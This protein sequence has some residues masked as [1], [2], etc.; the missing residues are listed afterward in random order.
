M[1]V[2]EESV[3]ESLAPLIAEMTLCMST[4]STNDS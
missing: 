2:F 4:L 1:Y 3:G